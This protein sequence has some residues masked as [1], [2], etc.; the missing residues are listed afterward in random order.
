MPKQAKQ[1]GAE[2]DRIFF[3]VPIIGPEP[4]EDDA[5]A[6][7]ESLMEPEPVVRRSRDL[8]PENDRTRPAGAR[9][10]AQRN[11]DR[12]VMGAAAGALVLSIAFLRQ[13]APSPAAQTAWVLGVAWAAL[14]GALVSA[15]VHH[16]LG[17]RVR[18][19]GVTDWDR[20][21]RAADLDD[22]DGD[23]NPR[24]WMAVAASAGLVIGLAS[25]AMF[26]FLNAG[27]A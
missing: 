13:I 20:T 12:V 7:I 11:V 10:H 5:Q 3:T 27:F 6:L 2:R 18:G 4:R 24:G 19:T 8:L 17:Q 25:L 15:L 16:H 21:F 26:A 22:P 1:K 9:H 23:S 14:V